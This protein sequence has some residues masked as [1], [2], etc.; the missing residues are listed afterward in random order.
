MSHGISGRSDIIRDS[1]YYRKNEVRGNLVQIGE[2]D[3]GELRLIDQ[4][5]SGNTGKFISLKAP[6][7]TGDVTLTL[8]DADGTANQVL[9]TDGGGALSWTDMG[10][11][12]T[13]LS[14][15]GGGLDV[16]DTGTGNTG[17]SIVKIKTKESGVTNAAIRWNFTAGGH[18]LPEVTEDYDI[19]SAD[20]KVRH[21]FLSDNSIRFK[22]T[23]D[24]EHSLGIDSST[25]KIVYGS[26]PDGGP[27]GRKP[28]L[29]IKKDG[30][31]AIGGNSLTNILN[32]TGDGVTVSS[33]N[34]TSPIKTITIAGASSGGGTVLTAHTTDAVFNSTRSSGLASATGNILNNVILDGYNYAFDASAP[35]YETWSSN[36]W[37]LG[38]GVA[39]GDGPSSG[40]RSENSHGATTNLS[41]QQHY[42]S[43]GGF[44]SELNYEFGTGTVNYSFQDRNPANFSSD[45]RGKRHW[46][47]GSFTIIKPSGRKIDDSIN[48]YSGKLGAADYSFGF[49]NTKMMPYPHK[50]DNGQ[51]GDPY[52]QDKKWRIGHLPPTCT[53]FFGHQGYHTKTGANGAQHRNFYQGVAAGLAIG[54]IS[55]KTHFHDNATQY[56]LDYGANGVY[57]SALSILVDE[58]NSDYHTGNHPGRTKRP[59]T[60]DCHAKL[61]LQPTL[62]DLHPAARTGGVS[63]GWRPAEHN[64]NWGGSGAN[65]YSYTQCDTWISPA[66]LHI[67]DGRYPHDHTKTHKNNL[68][69]IKWGRYQP[70]NYWML[71]HSTDII[72]G[73]RGNHNAFIR[74][75]ANNHVNSNQQ[76]TFETF[77]PH[78]QI[79]G[80]PDQKYTVG[81][82][83]QM[84]FT[85][86]FDTNGVNWGGT[87][88]GTM[89]LPFFSASAIQYGV[90]DCAGPPLNSRATENTAQ[91]EKHRVW[92]R[93]GTITC[94]AGSSAGKQS[95]Y[96]P[97]AYN[98]AGLTH[99]DFTGQNDKGS[100][101][102][103]TPIHDMAMTADPGALIDIQSDNGRK[104]NNNCQTWDE[105]NFLRIGSAGPRMTTTD[106]T[107]F[108]TPRSGI[109][110]ANQ[111]NNRG[112]V[113]WRPRQESPTINNYD[114]D[115]LH[116]TFSK[117]GDSDAY[118]TTD[119]LRSAPNGVLDV[120]HNT[121]IMTITG[122]KNVGIGT[123]TPDA[124]AVLDISG[125]IKMKK[126][127]F[128]GLTPSDSFDYDGGIMPYN[129]LMFRNHA[130][131]ASGQTM[132]ISG[133]GGIR[134]FT[135]GV[136]RL[137]IKSDGNV[138]IGT[139]TPTSKLS[140]AGDFNF[141]NH[142]IFLGWNIYAG[143]SPPEWRYINSTEAFAGS[144]KFD[145]NG[146][147]G[148]NSSAVKGTA[149]NV[150]SLNPL[151]TILN[152][153]NVG[154]G[155]TSPG[156][157]LEVAGTINMNGSAVSSDDRIKYNETE[158]T[159][160]LDTINKLKPLKYEKIIEQSQDTK[161][162]W[163]PTDAE[164]NNVK[165]S[166]DA[167]GN[168]LW[169]WSQEIGLIAQDIRN[170][171][172]YLSFCVG[173]QEHDASGNQTLLD[174][175]YNHIFTLSIA[176]LQE[177]DKQLQAEKTKTATLE[178]TVSSQQTTINDLVTRI[179]ALEN[180]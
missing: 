63:I 154:I 39:G 134:F 80:D 84:G 148:F 73:E 164:W 94:A 75:V 13:L 65:A 169:K 129:G 28:L 83:Y 180:A 18:L 2:T 25:G 23:G 86:K 22:D 62:R 89:A 72:L 69:N 168:K 48:R 11:G 32:F 79:T 35:Y 131:F 37:Y 116:F 77:G 6:Q 85:A 149:G 96:G 68:Q 21:L 173:G 74:S 118:H 9:Q 133:Y 144:I 97:I 31:D 14:T 135:L 30:G 172:P 101:G 16:D 46:E 33:D 4:N 136:E 5:N 99:T 104:N 130:S 43:L 44:L 19:G 165:D 12:S 122:D 137:T 150:V 45:V 40:Y 151:L 152:N 170:D 87:G 34:A 115:K 163:I 142:N 178:T 121:P 53:A 36:P 107:P 123:A 61:M 128:F 38:S 88:A 93:M 8:P 95:P 52:H 76:E 60:D 179:A 51:Y 112:F 98:T 171:I 143:G 59:S 71:D 113:I 156:V 90:D 56:N 70:R 26:F 100:N 64:V 54:N 92:I 29:E 108:S 162:I 7:L 167:N 78:T 176:A 120:A 114:A 66:V 20:K 174:V 10:G 159:S 49:P 146:N 111:L 140:V 102:T 109:V 119:A 147:F 153:G 17:T 110:I 157:K 50:W 175:K 1:K 125:N 177:V 126:D 67:Y 155:N 124:S 81:Y 24:T 41:N 57:L 47:I 91:K 132:Q 160:A 161:G 117:N 139:T 105:N 127:C 158:L 42:M 141:T 138:G 166:E 145:S 82:R 58:D 3:L 27:D 103:D 15:N 55:L 106:G